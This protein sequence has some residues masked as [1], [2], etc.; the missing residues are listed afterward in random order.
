[1]KYENFI[2]YSTLVASIVLGGFTG[3]KGR[4]YLPYVTRY[5]H[6]G[7]ETEDEFTKKATGAV[8]GATAGFISGTLLALLMQHYIDRTNKL[9]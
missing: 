4:E 7:L 8:G 5:I 6:H 9:N 2:V 3:Y 1:M